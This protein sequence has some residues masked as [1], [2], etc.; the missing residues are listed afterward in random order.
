[1]SGKMNINIKEIVVSAL[2]LAIISGV[3][4]AALAGTNAMTKDTI[5][6]ANQ[7]AETESRR[8]VIDADSFEKGI[9]N[10]DEQQVV[11]Y[12]AKKDDNIVGYVFTVS[13]TGKSSGLVVMT[14]I[15]V[16][17]GITG[18]TVTDDNETAG[19]VDMIQE[20]GLFDG[21]IGKNT[22]QEFS[23]GKNIDAV[24]Q[25]TKT[26]KGVT[27]GVN[28]AVEYFNRINKGGQ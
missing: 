7:K 25:A 20:G 2:A 4:N 6:Q 12:S 5:A 16:D 9:L 21:F 17:G 27:Q 24:S 23:I 1:M 15:S 22:S 10:N 3:A 13:S 26:S 14:G 11:Y 19:Y 18:V 28:Q 8:Q